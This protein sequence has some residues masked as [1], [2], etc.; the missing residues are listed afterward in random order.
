[1]SAKKSFLA[2]VLIV[3][4]SSII[5]AA[6]ITV[7][8]TGVAAKTFL[9]LRYPTTEPAK[10]QTRTAMGSSAMKIRDIEPLQTADTLLGYVVRLEPQGYI[11]LS[12][13]DHAPPVKL[14]SE[15][16][17]FEKLPPGFRTVIETE[18]L[19]DLTYL[20][21]SP[22]QTASMDTQCSKQWN[23]LLAP[24]NNPQALTEFFTSAA[25]G[26][27]ILTTTW[28]QN[29]PY[30]YYCPSASGGPGGRAYAGC[31]ATALAQVLRYHNSPVSVAANYTYTD[32]AGS[33]QGTY[34]IS[35]AGIGNYNWSNMP[36]SVSPTSPLAQKQAVG[37][38]IY[39]CAVALSSDF[40]ASETSAYPSDVP[41]VLQNYFSYTCGAY[42]WKSGYSS[43][44]WYSK[45]AID[46][47]A[48]N[49]I[50]YAMWQSDWSDGH[51]VVCDGYRNGNQIHLDLGWSGAGTAWYNIDSVSYGG[52]TWTQHGAV[53]GIVPSPPIITGQP[54]PPTLT[55]CQGQSQ[56]YC[57]TAS[58]SGLSYQWQINGGNISGATSSCYSATQSGSYRCVVSNVCGSVTSNSV[59]LT[60]ISAPVITGQPSPPTLTICQGQS[61]Q[62][63]VTASGSGLS[64]QWQI[65]GGNISGATSSCYSATQSGSYRCIVSNVCGSAT[66]NDATL[67]MMTAPS[68]PTG[69][70]ATDGTYCDKVDVSWNSVSG[71]IVYEI[72]RNTTND[73]GSAGY[74]AD[75]SASPYDDYSATVDVTYYYWVKAKNSCGTSGFSSSDTGYRTGAG[76]PVITQHPQDVTVYA[77]QD[78][79]F[80]V[81]AA[82]SAPLHY[83]W[84]KNGSVVGSDSSTLMLYS[85]QS[86]DNGAQI[87]C[88]VSNDCGTAASNAAILT[89]IT[90]YTITASAGPNGSIVPNGAIDVN[91]GQNL[92]FT[93]EPYPGYMVD[94]WYLDG[95]GVQQGNTTY[96]LY[97][98][99]ADRSVLVTFIE[100]PEVL[101][102]DADSPNDPGT[103][104]RNDPFRR[105]QDGI[106]A[107]YPRDEVWVAAGTYR[108]TTGTDRTISFIM[109]E[110]V[111]IYGG[112]TGTE[113]NRNQR[114]WV[115]N[116]TILSGD[117]GTP[118]DSADNSYHVV[119]GANNA[120]LDGFTITC[121]NAGYDSGMA[122]YGGGML[123]YLS[124]PTVINCTF[125]SNTA[126]YWGGGM[127]NWGSNSPTIINCT[128]S[129]NTASA[130]GG[131]VN[132]TGSHP[133]MIN[134]A[135]SENSATGQGGGML[136]YRSNNTTMTNCTFGGNSASY[137]GGGMFNGLY[138]SPIMTNC[139]FWG[140]IAPNGPQIYNYDS[141]S[142]PNITYSDIQGRYSGTGNIAAGPLFKAL[143]NL[144]LQAGSPCIDA[145]N[146]S[147]VP[148]GITT[149]LAG[150]PRFLD[151]SCTVDTGAGAPPIVDM[152][153]FEYTLLPHYTIT[154]SAGTNGS[155]EPAGESIVYV[156]YDKSIK[157]TATANHGYM[158]DTW[159]LDG[160]SVQQDG[161]TYT[162]YNVQADHNVLVTFVEIPPAIYVDAN[163]PNDHGTG[164]KEDPFR[165][166]Q[167]GID[168]V[169]AGGGLEVWVMAGTYKPTMDTD[170]TISFVMK[171]GVA[172][173]G[174]FTGTET[175]RE[176]RDWVANPTILSGDIG[177]EGNSSD[178]SYHV[179][180]GENNATLDGFT[181]AD[182][183]AEY[184]FGG[185]ML[186]YGSPT[187][188]N[189]IF[190]GNLA[191]YGGGMSNGYNNPTVTNCTFI[192]NSAAYDG[193]GMF[194]YWYSNAVVINCAF[195]GNSASYYGGGMGNE[196]SSGL[197]VTNCTFSGNMSING[198]VLA[199]GFW[200]QEYPNSVTM[201]NCIIWNGLDWLWNNDNSTI[202]ISY[203]DV[204][205]GWPGTGDIDA[206]PCFVGN[207]NYRL[208]SG[209]PCI[210]AGNNSAVPAGVTT[211]LDGFPRFIDGDCNDSNI[212]DMGA[213]E[214]LRSDINHDGFVNLTDFALL[215]LQW[216]QTG[217]NWADLHEFV[218][219]WLAGT[220]H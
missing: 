147:A 89:V 130:G 167:D 66:S 210:D 25:A 166:L 142:N 19:E 51:A 78:A 140:N 5:Y 164:T 192:G 159:Y 24:Q 12:A 179:V 165:R 108:P 21:L 215:A 27:A 57:V 4:I 105:L 97:N 145:G 186:N 58:G 23:A 197:T 16:G 101:Y 2:S 173:Y 75:D 158:V 45:I 195:I 118:D 54:S 77:G 122:S 160:D 175:R 6:P 185:G 201:A 100:I 111:A 3:L 40:E 53:F 178:N 55:I 148:T 152:G 183:N 41:S 30:N 127:A 68:P 132:D 80:S 214:F 198:T 94:T 95:S 76:K 42:E 8:Q 119:I 74:L 83:Q 44:A 99:Q 64:Y 69:V 32:N 104:T 28:N 144:R 62:Y 141:S 106:Y 18:L 33:C 189:C 73:S 177:I 93:A 9:V 20:S 82:G 149:D 190:T 154:A 114:D 219:Y 1:M 196:Y 125:G 182:G 170:R 213:Y 85:V 211:D 169:Q 131:M 121:G 188:T 208:L 81:A 120:T 38:L 50:F 22:A 202:T 71:A 37:Q 204:N 162:L 205:G 116:Q 128:F 63:C 46:I 43:S 7:E 13:D 139:I 217:I 26:T 134:C 91:S 90:I 10:A 112:F 47:G 209:S 176:Q 143:S 126:I 98:V 14:Y 61:Q 129:G 70:S 117:I 153:A 86:A 207:G 193:G 92:T 72:W 124:S 206:D 181:I 29:D 200:V 102:V 35:D 107:A 123:N 199:C 113:T 172:I 59:A 11:L 109:K 220:A 67:T 84:K 156:Y 146:N 96:T 115:A 180:V 136:N 48:N 174:G 56:Q 184:G 171:P 191:G 138:S 212:V 218:E 150:N 36:S 15:D 168:A 137:S 88:V 157:F 39:H 133:T 17:S 216:S 60:V 161:T 155:I 187:V 203:S 135:F 34:S 151:D 110:G 103:G 65:N 163:S 31:T 49:P 194:N 87:T 79:G 52:Y